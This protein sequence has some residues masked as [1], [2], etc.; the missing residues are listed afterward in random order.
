MDIISII[1]SSNIIAFFAFSITAISV[2]YQFFLLKQQKRQAEKPDIP[3]FN[4]NQNYGKVRIAKIQSE[5]ERNAF[6]TRTNSMSIFISLFVMFFF[7]IIFLMGFFI[8]SQKKEAELLKK[9]K[10]NINIVAS[11]G[12]KI[13]NENWEEL[14]D[15]EIKEIKKG[16]VVLVGIKTIPKTD[17]DGARIKI[18]EENWADNKSDV[19]FNQKLEVF[20]KRYEIASDEVKLKIEAQLHSKKQGWL[21]E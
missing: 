9:N 10:L 11:L 6:F 2:F 19:F 16:D 4:A 13:Y 18:N 12:I 15:S 17:V 5:K 7:G 21:G 14:K 8:D 20:Y 3:D 1:Q